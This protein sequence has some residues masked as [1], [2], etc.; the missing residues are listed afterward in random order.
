MSEWPIYLGLSKTSKH[1][2]GQ[3]F[4]LNKIIAS[5]NKV[6][7]PNSLGGRINKD[8]NRFNLS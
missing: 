6:S 3:L 8:V 1:V 7:R 2:P 5:A 4:I